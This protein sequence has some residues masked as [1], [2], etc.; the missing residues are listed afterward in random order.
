MA[1]MVHAKTISTPRPEGWHHHVSKNVAG[2]Y[3]KCLKRQDSFEYL[4]SVVT[5]PKHSFNPVVN[6]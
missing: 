4:V 3:F 2:I 5:P 1:R 6:P